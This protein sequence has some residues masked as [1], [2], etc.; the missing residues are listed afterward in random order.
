M[1]G[2]LNI[3]IVQACKICMLCYYYSTSFFFVGRDLEISD[4]FVRRKLLTDGTAFI[5][6]VF[7]RQV[8]GIHRSIVYQVKHFVRLE[9]RLSCEVES[10]IRPYFASRV[11]YFFFVTTL[12]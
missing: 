9:R 10:S 11:Q 1:P 3:S 7:G 5:F 12:F 8:S 2:E 4:G 6:N